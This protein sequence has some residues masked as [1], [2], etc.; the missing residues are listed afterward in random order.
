MTKFGTDH[1][2]RV[3]V[4]PLIVETTFVQDTDW[5]PPNTLEAALELAS[6]LREEL[7]RE[8]KNWRLLQVFASL[9][10]SY[11]EALIAFLI[12]KTRAKQRRA[13]KRS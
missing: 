1:H 7:E 11:L 5:L 6:T 4:M 3:S 13:A 2:R 8:P 10:A 12:W 9:T